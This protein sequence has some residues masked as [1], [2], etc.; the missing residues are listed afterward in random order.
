MFATEGRFSGVLMSRQHRILGPRAGLFEP[1]RQVGNAYP[2][3]AACERVPAGP[4]DTLWGALYSQ[5][6]QL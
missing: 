1:R 5:D 4:V 2:E 3:G 6:S